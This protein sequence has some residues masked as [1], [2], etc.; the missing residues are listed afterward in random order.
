MSLS[1]KQQHDMALTTALATHGGGGESVKSATSISSGKLFHL[2]NFLKKTSKESTTSYSVLSS[3]STSSF[4]NENHKQ[5]EVHKK[6]GITSHKSTSPEIVNW[7]Y[8][9]ICKVQK[10]IHYYF[11]LLHH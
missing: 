11:Y 3:L 8:L 1:I 6:Q 7:I 9:I 5:K 4:V 10:Q 2:K